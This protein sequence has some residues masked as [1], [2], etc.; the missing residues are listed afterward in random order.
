MTKKTVSAPTLVSK[1][2]MKEREN[3]QRW[4]T[5]NG[6]E[7]HT[8]HEWEVMRIV[9][10]SGTHVLYYNRNGR[11]TWTGDLEQLYVCYKT[12][13]DAELF[14]TGRRV[15]SGGL[16]KRKLKMLIE[17][18]GNECFF[19]G[20]EFTEENPPSLEELFPRTCG[21]STHIANQAL[22]CPECNQEAGNLSVVEKV[23]IRDQKRGLS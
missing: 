8:P 20:K 15:K 22:A 14:P 3:F 19:C 10:A 23:K 4:A 21:G 12:G 7:V 18:D 5:A 17:R 13:N 9:T 11:L 16:R 1:F 6:A 2:S